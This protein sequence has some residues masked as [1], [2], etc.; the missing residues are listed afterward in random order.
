M[1]RTD[2]LLFTAESLPLE[3]RIELVEKLLN[4]LNP[5]QKKI[6]ALW[7]NEAEKRVSELKTGKVKSIPGE[8]VFKEIQERLSR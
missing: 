5:P 8:E 7:A 3:L 2:E 1:I 6:D 4:S